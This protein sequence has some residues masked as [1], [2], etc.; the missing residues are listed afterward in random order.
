MIAQAA[1]TSSGVP[2][3]QGAG[4]INLG[5]VT[6]RKMTYVVGSQLQVPRSPSKSLPGEGGYPDTPSKGVLLSPLIDSDDPD[7]L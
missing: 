7:A 3:V 4:G 1:G 2:R 5:G 6:P